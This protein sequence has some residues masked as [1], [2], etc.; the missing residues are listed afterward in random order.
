MA[1]DRQKTMSEKQK[2]LATIA[3]AASVGACLA[4]VLGDVWDRF[5]NIFVDM[6]ALLLWAVV[7]VC[8]RSYRKL[9]KEGEA[10]GETLQ[11]EICSLKWKQWLWLGAVLAVVVVV[12]VF[13][14]RATGGNWNPFTYVYV[15]VTAAVVSAAS[16][17]LLRYWGLKEREDEGSST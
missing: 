5:E 1:S 13:R 17:I 2:R 6:V 10:R 11:R 12:T 4:M 14:H 15:I 8:I 9:Y 7:L 3:G 16:V